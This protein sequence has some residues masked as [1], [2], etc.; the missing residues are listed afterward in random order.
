[1]KVTQL[2]RAERGSARFETVCRRLPFRRIIKL[3]DADRW[4]KTEHGQNVID[5]AAAAIAYNEA[6]GF[7]RIWQK[8][9]SKIL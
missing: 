3:H 4:A 5:H 2:M 7:E 1:M 8:I 6:G 9:K